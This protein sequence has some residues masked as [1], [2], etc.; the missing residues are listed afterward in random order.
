MLRYCPLDKEYV[1]CSSAC[2]V[3]FEFEELHAFAEKVRAG[4]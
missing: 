2:D 4:E 3:C 1:D